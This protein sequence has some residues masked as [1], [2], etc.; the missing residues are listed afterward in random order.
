M[1]LRDL[2]V[3]SWRAAPAD[4]LRRFFNFSTHVVVESVLA[5][6]PR[7]AV[8]LDGLAK[9]N[10]AVG[11]A[12]TPKYDKNP[13]LAVGTYNVPDFDFAHYATLSEAGQQRIILSLLRKA[14][15]HVARVSHSD[16]SVCIEAIAQVRALGLPLPRINS[17]AFWKTMPERRRRSKGFREDMA[18]IARR[19]S[20]VEALQ[21]AASGG[22]A[23]A[24]PGRG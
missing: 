2:A 16:A 15:A 10:V 23:A 20:E 9:L 5:R 19:L 18:R 3:A 8:T 7:N 13:K 14:F 4:P 1:Y 6:I 11:D 22:L 24:R 21:V 12:A 17:E